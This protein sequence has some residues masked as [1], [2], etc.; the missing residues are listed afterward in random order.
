[1]STATTTAMSHATTEPDLSKRSNSH[2]YF[3]LCN[4]CFWC[5]SYLRHMGTV[6]CSSCKN[7]IIEPI[8][9]RSDEAFLFQYDRKRGVSLQFLTA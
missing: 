8:P 9:I 4:S 5:A 3:A 2:R 1:M 6:K 7:E